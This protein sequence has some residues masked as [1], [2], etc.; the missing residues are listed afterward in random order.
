M[1]YAIPMSLKEAN[2]FIA[3]RH[4]HLDPVRFHLFNIGVSD[5]QEVCGATAKP[6]RSAGSRRRFAARTSCRHA[7]R[8]AC[9]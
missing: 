6:E 1:L 9:L 5:G 3:E 7:A 2:A 4:R 8:R